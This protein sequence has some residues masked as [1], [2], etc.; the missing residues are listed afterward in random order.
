MNSIRTS[1]EHAYETLQILSETAR[2]DSEILLC[3][4]LDKNRAFLR[5]WPEKKLN[6]EQIVEFQELVKKRKNGL[7]I[8]YLVGIK[9]FWSREFIVNQ[10][11]LIPRPETELLI[12]LALE[13]IPDNPSKSIVDLGTGS[14]AIGITLAAERPTAKIIAT[15]TSLQALE[16]AKTNAKNHNI[17]NIKFLVS[18]WLRQLANEKHHL[19]VSN[20]PYIASQDPHLQQGDIRFEPK[21][22]L[23]ADQH[24]LSDIFEIVE[25]ARNF[26]C[27]GGYLIIEHGFNQKQQVQSIYKK[28]KYTN[29]ASHHDLAGQPR[30]TLGQWQP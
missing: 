11:V 26:L 29:I 10:H 6:P 25:T 12:E 8:A 22:A 7:P 27:T 13:L 15:D 21:K 5:A 30:I 1:L 3:H 18:H 19:I 14:G 2:L 20:P 16:V 4:V 17:A 9:E 28:F 24:G 23:I